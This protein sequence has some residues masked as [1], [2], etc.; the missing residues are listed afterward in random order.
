[1][2]IENATGGSARDL[3]WGNDVANVLKG[4][5]GNDVL[6]GFGGN[7]ELWGGAGDDTFVFVKDGSTDTIK[8]FQSGHDKIDLTALAGVTAADVTYNAHGASGANRHQPR[9]AGRHVH[10][11][12]GDAVASGDYLFHA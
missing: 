6:K 9:H 5:G 11:L 1:M 8:D 2:T 4:L 3:L 12:A 7:D 10:Q